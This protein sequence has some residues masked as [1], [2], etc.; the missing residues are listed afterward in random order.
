MIYVQLSDE[1]T[2]LEKRL[3][4]ERYR[5]LFVEELEEDI[6]HGKLSFFL[7]LISYKFCS[8]VLGRS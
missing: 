8:L 1:E 5:A 6:R 3:D 2:K 7:C 4:E